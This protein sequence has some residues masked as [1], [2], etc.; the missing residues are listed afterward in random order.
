MIG[1]NL[2]AQSVSTGGKEAMN[3]EQE[4]TILVR[5]FKNGNIDAYNSIVKKY[6]SRLYAVIYRMTRE[7]KTTDDLLQETF[8]KLYYS[9]GTFKDGYPFYPWVY[10]IAVN[11]TL[12]Y[13]KKH[14][15]DPKVSIEGEEMQVDSETSLSAIPVDD[16]NPEKAFVNQELFDHVNNAM[17]ELSPPMRA[18]FA[19]RIFDGR[20][21]SE[22]AQILKCNLGTVMSRLN[23]AREKMKH[24]LEGYLNDPSIVELE[25]AK[26]RS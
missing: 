18:V 5:D 9:I 23:R 1:N 17:L 26:C 4:D 10:R 25:E 12:N 3:M 15:K 2:C 6:G 19:L 13:L 21:Y 22:I 11:L 24:L 7:H 20:T 14:K 16:S 8:I